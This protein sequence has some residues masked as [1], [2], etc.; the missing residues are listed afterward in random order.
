MIIFD[1]TFLIDLM[2]SPNNPRHGNC[3]S[4][5][6][7]IRRNNEPYATTFVNVLELNKGVYRSNNKKKTKKNLDDILDII[8]ILNFN[9]AYYEQYGY[10]SAFLER[11]GTP[12]GM[13]DELIAAIALYHG[14]RVIT[15][16]I[17]DFSR[18]PNLEI[19]SH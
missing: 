14:A 6:D 16:N 15:N 17:S 10:L 13:F 5:L 1:S 4:L 3:S 12:L 7:N 18:V 8:P 2:K 11:K 19:I 9:A